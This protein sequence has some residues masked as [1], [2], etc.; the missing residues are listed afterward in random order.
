MWLLTFYLYVCMKFNIIYYGTNLYECQ[1]N[2]I[3]NVLMVTQFLTYYD[4][5]DFF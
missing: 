3:C 5:S 4:K 1:V 2:E